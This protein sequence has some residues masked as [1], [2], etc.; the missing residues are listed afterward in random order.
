MEICNTTMT[1][2]WNYYNEALPGWPLG[3]RPRMNRPLCLRAAG[4]PCTAGSEARLSVCACALCALNRRKGQHW[5]AWLSFWSAVL[6]TWPFSCYTN[7]HVVKC[8]ETNTPLCL[9]LFRQHYVAIICDLLQKR[10]RVESDCILWQFV[11]VMLCQ[12][13][14]MRHFGSFKNIYI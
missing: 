10:V 8:C 7:K 6:I 13:E 5:C 4:T 12:N 11:S 2:F 9:L 14:N 1:F 3:L